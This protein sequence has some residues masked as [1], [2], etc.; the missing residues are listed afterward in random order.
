VV[1]VYESRRL[2]PCAEAVNDASGGALAKLVRRFEMQASVGDTLLLNNVPDIT[3]ERV[4]LVGCGKKASMPTRQY[5]R[6][7]KAGMERLCSAGVKDAAVCLAE[8][9]VEDRDIYWKIRHIV[10]TARDCVYRFN[11]LKSDTPPAGQPKLHRVVCAIRA[12]KEKRRADE[13]VRHGVAI[14]DGVELARDLGNLPANICTPTYLADRARQLAR[15][16]K[17]VKVRVMGEAE[18]KRLGMGTLLSVSRGSQEPAKLITLEYRGSRAKKRPAVLIGKGVTFDSGGISIKPA[19]QM[20][21]MKFD[22]CGAASV[23]GAVKTVASLALPVNLVGI[24]AATENLPSSTASK[25]G[26]IYTSMSGQSVEVLNTDAEG[27]LVLCD[28]LT[29][30]SRFEPDVVVDVA[31]LTGACVV[32]LGAQAAGLF[33][34]NDRLAESLLDAGEFSH[35]RAWRMPLWDEYAE[36]LKSNF[37]DVANVGGREAGAITAACFLSRFARE[38]RW[39]HLDIAGV[40]WRGGKAKGATGRPVRLLSQ[41]LLDR[42]GRKRVS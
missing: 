13:G 33:S 26:D 29:Y 36:S 39:A 10:E 4:L 30:A 28:A 40:A 37:A 34:N 22:M 2:S 19:A 9:E 42:A 21:E 17:S 15:K 8:L 18:M 32:A 12:Q 20:D 14:S 25:P 1:G 24:V 11:Q 38:Y 41:F 6:L 23:M 31:T 27:R 35:D 3:A 7:V 5:A 16:E